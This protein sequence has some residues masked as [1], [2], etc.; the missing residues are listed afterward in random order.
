M[1]KLK[2]FINNQWVEPEGGKYFTS[3]CPATGEPLAELALASAGDVI[4][5]CRQVRGSVVPLPGRV[6]YYGF[7]E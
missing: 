5:L 6:V 1:K 4:R 3:F 7:K 2:L